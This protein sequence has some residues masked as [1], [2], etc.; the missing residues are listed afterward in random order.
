[1]LWAETKE[2]NSSLESKDLVSAD[3]NI[4][5]LYDFIIQSAEEFKNVSTYLSKGKR[6]VKV[7]NRTTR[8]TKTESIESEKGKKRRKNWRRQFDE[9]IVTR[10]DEGRALELISKSSAPV[11]PLLPRV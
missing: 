8:E 7:D 4:L 1:M 5:S 3:G 11:A 10:R 6:T 2:E 9:E